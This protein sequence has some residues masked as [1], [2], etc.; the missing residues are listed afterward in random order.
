MDR[1]WETITPLLD[2]D[3]LVTTPV[4]VQGQDDNGYFNN[5][6]VFFLTYPGASEFPINH[7]FTGFEIE[8]LVGNAETD[9]YR[10]RVF[11]NFN[12]TPTFV[13]ELGSGSRTFSWTVGGS[14]NPSDVGD[15]LFY[16]NA[17]TFD[18]VA[19]DP[20]QVISFKI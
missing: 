20:I 18:I 3:A 5:G 9:S 8:V 15:I 17:L 14:N 13:S 10:V 16:G 2:F 4:V 12:D 11:S 19:S 7:T 1:D 6:S